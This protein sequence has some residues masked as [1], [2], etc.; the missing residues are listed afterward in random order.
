MYYAL[1]KTLPFYVFL[2]IENSV[3]DLDTEFSVGALISIFVCISILTRVSEMSPLD[4]LSNRL[5]CCIKL[6]MLP[7]DILYQ[8]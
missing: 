1:K 5:V 7:L 4:T 8:A 3:F 2:N 6:D